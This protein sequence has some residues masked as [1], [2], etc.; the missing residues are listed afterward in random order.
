LRIEK[1]VT[2]FI[3]KKLRVKT[4]MPTS[5]YTSDAITVFRNGDIASISCLPV[6]RYHGRL[7]GVA[8]RQ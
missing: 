7:A 4:A 8:R 5:E 2:A 1:G 3:T 6:R